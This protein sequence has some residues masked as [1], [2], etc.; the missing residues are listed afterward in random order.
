LIYDALWS[1]PLRDALD[2]FKREA[3]RTHDRRGADTP[4]AGRAVVTGCRSPFALYD[5]SLA[6]YGAG[7]TSGTTPPADSSQ[8]TGSRSRPE[9]PKASEAARAAE[10]QPV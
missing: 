6:T 3:R 9:P 10:P 7:D 1:S 8:F 5:E 4:A 2:A